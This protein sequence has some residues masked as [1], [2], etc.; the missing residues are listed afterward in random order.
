M[1]LKNTKWIALLAVAGMAICSQTAKAV[2]INPGDLVFGVRSTNAS[3]TAVYL[4][5]LGAPPPGGGTTALNLGADL[6]ALFGSGWYTDTSLQW[7]ISG[8]DNVNQI[9][10][11]KVEATYGVQSSAYSATTFS[12]SARS[13]VATKMT[14]VDNEYSNGSAADFSG[15]GFTTGG[16]SALGGVAVLKT[17]V[18]GYFS[19]MPGFGLFS[20][21]FEAAGFTNKELDVYHIVGTTAANNLY[22]GSFIVNANGD[23]IF[24]PTA[25]VATP[26]AGS[27][28]S[29]MAVGLGCLVTLRRRM[30]ARA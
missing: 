30:V 25:A 20:T 23:V 22:Q 28:L 27:A 7:S 29:L 8:F 11:S 5:D 2:T 1:K 3:V 16:T 6:S 17:D 4:F 13:T 21:P 9:Y 14:N 12:S 18:N 19:Q 10:A 26:E 24:S 15:Q